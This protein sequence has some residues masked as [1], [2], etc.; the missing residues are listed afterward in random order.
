MR[1]VSAGAV[2]FAVVFLLAG[3]GRAE[4]SSVAVGGPVSVAQPS[5]S[6]PPTTAARTATSK[7]SDSTPASSLPTAP[8]G[9]RWETSKSGDTSILV[10]KAWSSIDLTKDDIEA[11]IT[12]VEKVNAE[13]GSQMRANKAALRQIA[14]Y[15]IGP[16][17]DGFAANVNAI[18]IPSRLPVDRL[19]EGAKEQLA[20]FATIIDTST[21][22]VAGEDAAVLRYSLEANGKSIVGQQIYV[23]YSNGTVAFTISGDVPADVFELMVNSITFVAE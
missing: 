9:Y 20:S 14:L 2:A 11:M 19:M 8:S 12:E 3:C 7:G 6:A 16:T 1:R 10:P 4:E 13:L 17:K 18:E 23:P 15:A 22:K 5:A 21:R